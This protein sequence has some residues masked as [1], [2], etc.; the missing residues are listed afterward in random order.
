MSN[1]IYNNLSEKELKYSYWYVTHRVFLR[2][3]GVLALASCSIGLLIYGLFLV[4]SYYIEDAS[5]SRDLAASLS[6]DKLNLELLAESNKPRDLQVSE[7]RVLRGNQG[8][9]DFVATIFNPNVQWAVDKL[10]YYFLNGEDKTEL[11]TA[12]IL[13]GQEKYLLHFNYP[14]SNTGLQVRIIIETVH[15]QK[16]VDFTAQQENAVNFEITNAAITSIIKPGKETTESVTNV[17]FDVLNRSA[18][19]FWEP[20][21]VVL[22]ERGDQLIAVAETHLSTLGSNELRKESINLFQT[23]PAS[24]QLRVVPDINILDPNVFKGFNIEVGERK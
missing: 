2:K 10:E 18:Y 1:N 24:T 14:S 13:P 19:S 23:L 16:V 6:Q 8:M 9:V 17:T 3:L 12:Y 15:W 20:R 4:S 22:L 11:A 7:T 21:F 5:K